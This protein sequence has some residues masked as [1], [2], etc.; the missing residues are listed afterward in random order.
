MNLE[1]LKKDW[2]EA[3]RN[4]KMRILLDAMQHYG[5]MKGVLDCQK[6]DKAQVAREYM[7]AKGVIRR[8]NETLKRLAH[9]APTN[10]GKAQVKVLTE[11]ELKALR[12]KAAA[13]EIDKTH[14][15]EQKSPGQEPNHQSEQAP[16]S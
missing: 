8:A 9:E 14:T 12:E 11:D 5:Y 6:G 2:R 3:E 4:V 10:T 13:D 16:P 15:G 1:R 7:V